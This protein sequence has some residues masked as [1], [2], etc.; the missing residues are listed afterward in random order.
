MTRT[1]P[2]GGTFSKEQE[3]IYDLVLEA[4]EAGIAKTRPGATLEDVH[5]ACV[6]VITRG[7]VRLGLLQ[8]E[9]EQLLKDEAYKPFFMH[10]TSHWLGMDVH[11]V[12]SYHAGGRARPL[13][14][15]MVL[16]VEPGIYIGAEYDKVPA[17]YRGI[18][19]RIEDD[20][21]VTAGEPENLTQAIPKSVADLSRAYAA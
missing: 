10:K 4:Q 6:D 9:P 16:T 5:G 17:A 12:G 14:P 2:V 7:L 21:V 19:V 1:V 3:A 8:G 18:G 11:D 13:E 20:I 15:G